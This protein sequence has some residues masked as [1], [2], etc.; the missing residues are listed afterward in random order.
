MT[1]ILS[2]CRNCAALLEPQDELAVKD[3]CDNCNAPVA[4]RSQRIEGEFS[5]ADAAALRDPPDVYFRYPRRTSN[6]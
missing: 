4:E 6:A 3:C 5:D 2:F 1:T